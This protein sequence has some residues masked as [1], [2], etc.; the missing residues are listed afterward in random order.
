MP[1]VKVGADTHQLRIILPDVSAEGMYEIAVFAREAEGAPILHK[2]SSAI[3]QNHR[4]EV[5][6]GMDFSRIERGSYLLAIRH[7]DSDWQYVPLLRE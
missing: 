6:V 1:P 5:R 4:L 2:P 3:M 7:G